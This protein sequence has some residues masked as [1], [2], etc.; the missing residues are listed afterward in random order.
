MAKNRLGKGLSALITEDDGKKIQTEQL[1][2]INIENIEPNPFQPRQEFDKKSLQKLG[3]S[4][5]EEGMLQPIMVRRLGTDQ[6]QLVSGER[7]WRAARLIDA[8]KIPALVRNYS[9]QQ[10]MEIALVENLQREDLNPIEEAQAYQRMLEDF[11]LTQK[12][13]ADKVG[14]SRSTV[15]NLIRLLNLASKIQVYV[16]RET[17][18]VGHARALLSLKKEEKQVRAAEHIIENDLSVRETEEYIRRKQMQ[19][20]TGTDSKKEKKENKLDEKWYK[21]T[22]KLSRQI[23]K[24]VKINQKR[25]KKVINIELEQYHE[26]IE[27]VDL[28]SKNL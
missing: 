2:N 3:K 5:K 4:I 22:D 8:Q 6:Y 24:K 13:V 12:Q 7:R 25:N 28:L 21:A 15:S 19:S 18:S 11:D 1:S 26:L 23:G 10:M 9:D 16:S 20:R 27:L 14:K 17:L